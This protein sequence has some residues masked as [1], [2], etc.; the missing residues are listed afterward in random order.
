MT[1]PATAEVK[2]RILSAL[3]YI[4]PL[5]Y[6]LPFGISLLKQIPFLGLIYLPLSPLISLYYSLPFGGL[7]IFF[8]LF[9]AVV[10][11]ERVNRFIRF[12]TLQA[13]LIDIALI[14]CSLILQFLGQILVDNSL[15]ILTLNNTIFLGTLTA[16]IFG[17]IQSGRGLYPEIPAISEAVYSQLPW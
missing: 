9:F 1:T 10:R 11:N 8:V 6:A 4:L 7:I 14:L 2:D 5:I 12:N 3:V 13:I 15:F 17:I 16:C